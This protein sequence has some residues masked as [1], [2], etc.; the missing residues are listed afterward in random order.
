MPLGVFGANAGVVQTRRNRMHGQC[1]AIVVLEDD[2]V[3]PVQ[4]A[5]PATCPT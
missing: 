2:C 4:H 5:R 1:L 3:H